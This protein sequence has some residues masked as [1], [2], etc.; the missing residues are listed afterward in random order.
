MSRDSSAFWY[1]ARESDRRAKDATDEPRR[2]YYEREARIWA[3]KARQA[4][5]DEA[6]RN[7]PG[8]SDSLFGFLTK[9][10]RQTGKAVGKAGRDTKIF[11]RRNDGLT[12]AAI[13]LE[14]GVTKETVRLAVRQIDRKAMWREVDRNAQRERVTSRRHAV[15]KAEA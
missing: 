9:V 1:Q 5:A 6:Y 14:F 10:T 12:F 15:G 3:Q 7:A 8:Y 4:D 11:A 2:S 13:G